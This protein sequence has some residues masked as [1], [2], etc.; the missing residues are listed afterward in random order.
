[1]GTQFD[2]VGPQPVSLDVNEEGGKVAEAAT[3]SPAPN[4]P[5]SH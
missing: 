2:F 4:S 3:L 1:M 5:L